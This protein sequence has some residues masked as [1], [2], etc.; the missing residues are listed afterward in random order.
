[1]SAK[2]YDGKEGTSVQPRGMV[3]AA[4]LPAGEP[5]GASLQQLP[6]LQCAV[7]LCH[8]AGCRHVLLHPSTRALCVLAAQPVPCASCMVEDTCGEH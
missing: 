8:S 3:P 6:Q 5:C 1:V 2:S 4:T 7:S